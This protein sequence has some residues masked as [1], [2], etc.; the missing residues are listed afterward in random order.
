MSL[1][2]TDD[3]YRHDAGL[4]MR[5]SQ[6]LFK[7]ATYVNYIERFK[8]MITSFN[9]KLNEHMSQAN[10]FGA[11]EDLSVKV[12]FTYGNDDNWQTIKAIETEYS[13]WQD[14]TGGIISNLSNTDQL[15]KSSLIEAIERFLSL[16]NKSDFSVNALH[17]HIDFE[18]SINDQGI[19]KTVN[20]L[21]QIN[22][23][24][25]QISSNGVS[26][27][28]VL[29]IFIGILNMRRNDNIIHFNWSLDELADI[30]PSNI[31]VLF[32]ML[33]QNHI[34]LISACTVTDDT[35][36]EAFDNVYTIMQQGPNK[37]LVRESD[38]DIFA[39]LEELA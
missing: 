21:K 38:E 26:H 18:F 30:D 9:S 31:L 10:Q 29:S 37:V 8:R 12:T 2:F 20:S 22:S 7:I 4:F 6:Q 39:E 16:P 19:E 27:L 35:V 32:K 13:A 11:I 15:P 1:Y 34:H 28:I 3:K 24:K 5:E 17:E 36:Y 33:K 23:D 14:S 25:S